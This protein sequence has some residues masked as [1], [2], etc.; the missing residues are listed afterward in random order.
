MN[1]VRQMICRDVMITI[2]PSM[3][4]MAT[5]HTLSS[6]SLT[7]S[8]IFLSTI[9]FLLWVIWMKGRRSTTEAPPLRA[10]IYLVSCA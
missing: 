10:G 1:H 7:G 8:R 4:T 5:L 9:A 2:S 3:I 6:A